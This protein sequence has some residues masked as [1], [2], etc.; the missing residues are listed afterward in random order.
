[1]KI[2]SV[3]VA[4]VTITGSLWLL[5]GCAGP[6]PAWELPTPPVREAPIIAEG[7]LI[8]RT[9]PNGLRILMLEDHSRPVVS[10]GLAVRRGIAIEAPGEEGVA[11]LCSEVMQRGAGDR[12]A[13]AMARSI[14]ELGA[15]FGVAASWDAIHI[16]A[17]GLARDADTFLQIVADVTLRPRFDE[18]EIQKARDEQ[19]AGLASGS[20]NPRTLL[21][22][23]LARTLYPEHR[24][25]VPS[26]GL[27]ESVRA[28]SRAD[29]RSYYD[30]VF[31]PN[32][33]VF[34]ATGDF[35]SGR[36]LE[37]VEL[38]LGAWA[39]HAVPDPVAAPPLRVPT[40]RKV[41]VVDRPELSQVRIAVAHEGLR[42]SDPRRI[43]ASLLN[44]ILGGSG[45]S[46]RLTVSIRS[47]AGLTY[48]I[49]SGFAL[50]RRPGRFSVTT[51]TR[52]N[53][54]RPML[55][56]LL[57]EVKAIRSD[58]PISEY[59]L[60]NAKAFSVGQ[61]ALGLE[62]SVAV[63]GSLVNLDLYDLPEDSLDTYRGRIQQVTHPEVKALAQE[64]LYPDRA[65]IVVVG[66]AEKLLPELESLGP[67]EVVTW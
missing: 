13:L 63:M 11:A 6:R 39:R 28:L 44:D 58:R 31:H 49:R 18:I 12:N 42:R 67:I 8:R 47:N 33:A 20:D 34:Y 59:E 43:P 66:P 29:V 57:A 54:V 48:S 22:W 51:F 25:G 53:Q 21:S 16:R 38:A 46:S 15:T 35:D 14:D 52:V 23:Q 4:G 3:L 7:S 36:L 1:M 60:R 64:L 45:F 2:R 27:P 55:D 5:S 40:A 41:V 32:N 30:R 56:L 19:L 9:L 24:Y 50:R 17:S 62:T 65:A 26:E 61:F 37:Q 10:F